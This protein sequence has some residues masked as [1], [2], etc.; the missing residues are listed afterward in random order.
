M[1][2]CEMNLDKAIIPLFFAPVLFQSI[3]PDSTDKLEVR[4][5]TQIPVLKKPITLDYYVP[6]DGEGPLFSVKYTPSYLC[7]SPQTAG[8]QYASTIKVS[9]RDIT[10]EVLDRALNNYRETFQTPIEKPGNGE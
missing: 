10:D 6:S 1:G 7:P 8:F 3:R 2:T 9:G 5:N 4:T